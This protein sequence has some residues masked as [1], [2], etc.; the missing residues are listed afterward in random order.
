MMPM[1]VEKQIGCPYCNETIDILIEP[2]DIQQSYIEDC[3]VC[4]RP[5]V[6][7]VLSVEANDAE[8]IVAAENDVV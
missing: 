7:N 3:Q 2:E 5:I 8:I 1:L 6:I 4:C